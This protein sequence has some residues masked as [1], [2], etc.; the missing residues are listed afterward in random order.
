MSWA[1]RPEALS[2]QKHK[3]E[4]SRKIKLQFYWP[5]PIERGGGKYLEKEIH[6]GYFSPY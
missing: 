5:R 1:E 6:D 4:I 3:Y 2:C